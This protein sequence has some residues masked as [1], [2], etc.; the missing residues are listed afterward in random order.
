MSHFNIGCQCCLMPVNVVKKLICETA[1]RLRYLPSSNIQKLQA[2]Q[3]EAQYQKTL[4]QLGKRSAL[5]LSTIADFSCPSLNLLL[6][7]L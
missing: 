2:F 7:Y 5:N 1:T 4:T 3:I 6:K